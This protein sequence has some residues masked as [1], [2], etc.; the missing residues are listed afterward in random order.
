SFI[1]LVGITIMMLLIS[2]TLTLIAVISIPLSFFV[3]RPLLQRSHRYF[4]EQQK[5]LGALNGHVEEMYTGNLV[6]KAYGREQQ[7]INTFDKMN[8]ELYNVGRRAQF[9]SGI[10]MP[11]MGFIGNIGYVIISIVGGIFV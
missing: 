6:V 2:P 9:I 7:S 11:L 3:I 8:G 1:T 5:T 10:M 4:S